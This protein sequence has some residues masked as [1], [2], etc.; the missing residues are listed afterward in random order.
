MAMAAVRLFRVAAVGVRGWA[1]KTQSRY[2]SA[3]SAVAKYEGT[4]ALRTPLTDTLSEF[5]ASRVSMGQTRS[6]PRGYVSAVRKKMSDCSRVVFRPSTRGLQSLENRHRGNHTWGRRVSV[7][8]GTEQIRRL[9]RQWR[10]WRAS[11]GS[12][13]CESLKRCPSCQ[14]A[15][16]VI[17]WSCSS[18]PK[19]VATE[20]CDGR[21]MSG[22][23]RGPVPQMLRRGQ[24][25]PRRSTVG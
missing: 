13:S 5:L 21:F 18:L 1:P 6:T 3:P 4:G 9:S 25:H 2:R 10:H 24:L 15:W 17:P 11:V 22:D 8:C 12:S 19:L 7:S 16:G 20:K 14:R 23:G